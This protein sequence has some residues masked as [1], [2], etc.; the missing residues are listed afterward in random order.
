MAIFVVPICGHCS[1]YTKD[2]DFPDLFGSCSF[3]P[4]RYTAFRANG[5]KQWEM[6]VSL[7]TIEKIKMEFTG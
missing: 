5:C 6:R 3:R 2:D 4:E 1:H 7:D